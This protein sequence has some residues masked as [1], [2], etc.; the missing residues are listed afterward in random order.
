M[1]WQPG[2]SAY[3]IRIKGTVFTDPTILVKNTNQSHAST[4]NNISS[5]FPKLS[6]RF[7]TGTDPEGYTVDSIGFLFHEIADTATAASELTCEP[8]R[9][10][11]Q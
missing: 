11:R 6:Q 1:S 5:A 8:A 7:T 4:N 9:R 3:Q 10:K 2:L